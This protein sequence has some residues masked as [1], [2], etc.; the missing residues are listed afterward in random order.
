MP[1]PS[2]TGLDAEV[3]TYGTKEGAQIRLR[4]MAPTQAG[5]A[6][7]VET[8]RGG[9]KLVTRL[10]GRFN[11]YNILA[12]I[13]CGLA[14]EIGLEAIGAGLATLESVP[15]RF[16]RV[17]AGQ[18]F[19]VVVDYAHTPD[20]LQR[21][22]Q[23]ARE[24]TRARLL[25]VFGCGGD[26]DRGKR[27]QMGRIAAAAADV[28]YVTSD[29]PRSEKPEEIIGEIVAGMDGREAV[30][31]FPERR[32]AIARALETADPGDVVVIAGKGH[33]TYQEV[34]GRMLDFDD[35]Q[36]RASS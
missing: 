33:E 18:D 16:E 26:R 7:E 2:S 14:L 15:G 22:L 1:P 11:C 8:P 6:L 29:N 23:A 24:L 10:T 32:E 12:A 36:W 25:C 35:R 9:V 5:M 28:V 34:A 13:G 19:E 21:L 27:P 20:A 3:L 30:R 31:I 4:Q 17:V